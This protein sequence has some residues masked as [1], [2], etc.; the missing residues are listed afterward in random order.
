MLS[1]CTALLSV[2]ATI[3]WQ[4]AVQATCGLLCRVLHRRLTFSHSPALTHLAEP[5]L[6]SRL[7]SPSASPDRTQ[8]S[9]PRPSS[10][11]SLYLGGIPGLHRKCSVR[12]SS[13]PP[14]LYHAFK[15]GEQWST[16]RRW[17]GST[18]STSVRLCTRPYDLYSGAAYWLVNLSSHASLPSS[19]S[20]ASNDRQGVTPPRPTAHAVSAPCTTQ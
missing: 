6:T 4:Q 12:Q 18:H 8:A 16:W 9:Y 3:G 10:T 5:R 2:R 19:V 14:S 7:I 13:S 17:R 11:S 15:R 1:P 20:V